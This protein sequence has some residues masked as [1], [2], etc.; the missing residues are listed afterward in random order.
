MAQTFNLRAGFG[1]MAGLPISTLVAGGMRLRGDTMP[2]LNMPVDA[3]RETARK[4]RHDVLVMVQLAA[5][6]HPGGPLSAADYL[7]ALWMNY[8]NVDPADATWPERDRFML[9]NGHCSAINYA[10][11]AH[12]GYFN[13]GYLLTFRHLNSRLQG[14]PSRATLPGIEVSTGSLG[15][16]LSVSHGMALGARMRG[17]PNINV[18][19]NCGDGELQEGNIWEAVMHAGHRKTDNLVLSVDWNNAQIDGYVENVKGIEPLPDKFK[20]FRWRVLVAGG[21][22]MEEVVRTWDEALSGT[23]SRG[24]GCGQPTVILWK[25]VMMKGCPTFENVPGW[26]G[27]APKEDELMVML[28]ELGY[29]YKSVDEARAAMGPGEYNGAGGKDGR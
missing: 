1:R 16:G 17:K 26:H 13:R 6:G 25:T 3:L 8:L 24:K 10:L 2:T 5:S 15:Q 28:K 27:R 12:R 9:S 29:N 21:H 20:A 14:H 19:C 7:T 18:F 11:M 22:D 4:I 23:P